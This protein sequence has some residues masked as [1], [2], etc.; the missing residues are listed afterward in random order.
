MWTTLSEASIDVNSQLSSPDLLR[1]PETFRSITLHSRPQEW[2]KRS[3]SNILSHWL[4]P[5]EEDDGG[6]GGG[7]GGRD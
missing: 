5:E 7:G 3:G 1:L 6:D 4:F 2:I